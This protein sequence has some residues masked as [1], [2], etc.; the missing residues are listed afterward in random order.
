MDNRVYWIWL[1]NAF[2][3]GSPKPV[4]LV[5]RIGSAEKL[6]QGGTR[7]WSSFSFVSD[8]E[9]A[10][11]NAYG[12]EQAAAALE[13]YLKLG[14]KV[15]TP[16][17]EDYPVLL[18]EIYNPPAVLYV[19]GDLS[20]LSDAVSIS[21]VG[22]RKASQNGLNA[23]REI[24]YGLALKNAVVISGGA[25]GIDSEAH[26]GALNGRGKTIAILPCGLE[27]PYLM[28][29]AILRREI[30]D[31]GGALVTEYPMH[32]PVQR[33][34]FQ[35]RNRLISG[36]AHGVLAMGYETSLSLASDDC[37]QPDLQ[38][39]PK[40]SETDAQSVI[41]AGVDLVLAE[42]MDDSEKQTLE[43]A[44]IT[45]LL[46]T[47]AK[48]REDFE[49]LYA[50]VGTALNGGSTGYNVGVKAAQ[51]IFSSLDDLSRLAPESKTVVT[52]CYI[53]DVNGSA[54]TGD[55][56]GS[57]MMSYIGLTN[58]FKG[59]TGGTFTF[60]DLRLSDPTMIF[61]SEDV[62]GQIMQDAQYANLSAVKN[63]RVY[64]V[65]PN[66]MNWQGKTV[67]NAC[68]DMMGLA[69]PELTEE[70]SAALE[71]DSEL[72]ETEATASPS[73]APEYTAIKSGTEGDD[74]FAMQQRLAELGYLTVEYTGM[75][76]EV[77]MDAV[78][79]FQKVNGL[80]A[81]GE[82]DAETLT[83][84]YSAEAKAADG[85]EATATPEPESETSTAE[86]TVTTHEDA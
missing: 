22:T 80:T 50:Q 5:R 20:I 32:T 33:G 30:V 15:I 51:K 40:V 59:L 73:P 83:V 11:L 26:K 48:N 54:V 24:A 81:T 45:V 77:T 49:R 82:A 28:D 64:A 17:D 46:L 71:L 37:T 72:S 18:K 68:I 52:A 43:N 67:Y 55:E 57:V 13:Y 39:L 12:A 60:D 61:C 85:A 4:Q 27:Y 56:L 76:G 2:G 38:V 23:A 79:A 25:L 53:S 78:K 42:T 19:Q 1:Q 8:K 44:G 21:I 75:Y 3:A 66:Y 62:R 84:L 9:L 63:G 35:V 58:I 74:V 31:F 36:M 47:R 14:Q 6:Y 69:Y 86:G 34:A 29:N 16:D 70:N 41:S 7:L 10:A 65:D